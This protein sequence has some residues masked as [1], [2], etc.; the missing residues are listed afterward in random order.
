M[1]VCTFIKDYSLTLDNG[2]F[3]LVID[4]AGNRKFSFSDLVGKAFPRVEIEN[5]SNESALF[6]FRVKETCWINRTDQVTI[7]E[8]KK[9][10]ELLRHHISIDD[11]LDESH[12]LS[13]HNIP[14]PDEDDEWHLTPIGQLVNRTK[15]YS[16]QKAFRSK[17]AFDQIY[18]HILDF[19][20]AHP[21]YHRASII[22]SV[23]SS[24]SSKIIT[25]PRAIAS[26]VSE[27]LGKRLLVPKRLRSI[28]SQ[29]D[30][31]QTAQVVSRKELQSGT[32][33]VSDNIE[34]ASV[35]LIEDLYE[36]GGSIEETARACRS[37]GA[38]DVL[39]LAITK[40]AKATYGMRLSDW[41]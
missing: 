13:P 9:F 12:A 10:L 19:I 5:E 37:A 39:G 6:S 8:V 15:D 3:K 14:D 25:L 24:D 26:N 35:I 21:T 2:R 38:T 7:N 27:Q 1:P 36:T 33:G 41:S 4:Y 11:E 22:A 29:K 17:A 31:D 30:Y 28:P 32:V 34:G 20:N 40:T 16:G 18:I 23:P